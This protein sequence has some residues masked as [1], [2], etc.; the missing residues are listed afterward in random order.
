MMRQLW[1]FTYS[2]IRCDVTSNSTA[3]GQ[4]HVGEEILQR[5][6]T[7][8]L[9]ESEE[10]FDDNSRWLAHLAQKRYVSLW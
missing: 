9:S 2:E 7:G 3:I 8:I 10:G 6:T 4:P 5:V 1:I